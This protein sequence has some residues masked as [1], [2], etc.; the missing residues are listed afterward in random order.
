LKRS[1]AI[2]TSAR[3]CFQVGCP[4]ERA[5]ALASK[6]GVQVRLWIRRTLVANYSN[7]RV[8]GPTFCDEKGL[9]LTTRALNDMLHD[10][11]DEVRL[12]SPALFMADITS[13]ADIEDKYNVFR[14]FRRGSDA[15]A[16]AI[17]VC[18][19]DIDEINR[20]TKKEGAGTS[21][22]THKMQ[23]HYA[24]V[25]ILLPTFIRYTKVM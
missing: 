12:E 16:I 21:R 3:T 15:R 17:Q 10:I 19:N 4:G 22:P 2:T 1:K 14:S 8:T 18:P 13:R 25:N 6:S 11:L 23:H 7:A 9:V 20:W 5:L 24:D